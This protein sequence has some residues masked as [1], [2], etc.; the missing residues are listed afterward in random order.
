MHYTNHHAHSTFSDGQDTAEDC[1]LAALDQRMAGYG[2]SDHAP[3]VPTDTGSMSL[4]TLDDYV[5]ETERLRSAYG[6][7]IRVF[8]SLEVDYLPGRMSVDSDHIKSARL[9]YTVGAVHFIE[10]LDG[11][12]WSFQRP[13]PNFSRGID[14]IFGGDARAMV[15]RYFELVREMVDHHPPDIV[16]HLDRIKKRNLRGGF[17]DEHA[18]W[19]VRQIDLTLDRIKR[20]GLI[21]EVN[22]RGYY[23]GEIDETYPSRWIVA[24]AHTLGIPLQVNSD[25]HEARHI[26]AGFEFAFGALRDM[27]V[28]RVHIFTGDTFEAVA[29][30]D[31]LAV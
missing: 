8:R 23:K 27:G 21:L 14:E 7:R 4:A 18:D 11:H 15:E 1:L 2:F 3:L 31:I 12:P 25:S 24:R 5:T 10:E 9:D 17:W 22:T 28:E 19:F 20:A 30:A 6:D 29:L 13:E 26:T 16:A